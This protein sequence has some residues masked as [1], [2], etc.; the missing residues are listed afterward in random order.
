MQMN[1]SKWVAGGLIAV[2]AATFTFDA[3]AQRRMGGGK[4]LG[5]QSNQV[6]RQAAPPQQ[7]TP[8]AQQAA[9]AQ[10]PATAG[11]PTAA[12]GTAAA[13]AART[14]SP[15]RNMLIG[16]AAGLGLM[17]LA[18][19]LGFGEGLATILLFVLLGVVLFIVVGFIMR[20]MA[21]GAGNAPRP[22][23][24]RA[25]NGGSTGGYMPQPQSQREAEVQ[26]M[27]R[28]APQPSS[29]SNV[30]PGSAMDEFM[31]GGAV[32]PDAPWGVPAG[33][34]TDGFLTNA[35]TYFG[36]LQHAWDSGDLAELQDFTTNEMFI[37]L[38]HELRGRAGNSKTEVLALDAKLLGIESNATEHMASVRFTGELRVNGEIESF[39]EAWNMSKAADGKSGWLLAGIQQLA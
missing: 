38:T 11:A 28:A 23:Y 29:T 5:K 37:G 31:R 30:R 8:P 15:M 25:G 7:Q 35:K 4:N 3:E 21:G 22:A 6:Q 32:N 26:P 34:D 17:A 1:V 2:I 13:G 9:P 10:Q 14:A 33:F 27:Q 20:R 39:D 19:Y 24:A 36:K 12:A 16:A 18:S